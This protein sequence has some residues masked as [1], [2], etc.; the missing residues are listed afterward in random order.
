MLS[1]VNEVGGS[2]DT[3]GVSDAVP[4]CVSKNITLVWSAFFTLD[5][6][7]IFYAA[8]PLARLLSIEVWVTNSLGRA[9]EGDAVGGDGEAETG[10]VFPDLHLA[11]VVLS[12][13]EDIDFVVT[14]DGGG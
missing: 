10:G 12:A 1:P 13:I 5:N 9:G 8:G 4:L 3:D 2:G 11:G 6:A 7:G 14:D